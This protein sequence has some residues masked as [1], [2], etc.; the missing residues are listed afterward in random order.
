MAKKPIVTTINSVNEIVS[1][2]NTNFTNITNQFDNTLSRDGSTP[3]NMNADLDMNSNDVLNVN[4]IGTNDITVGGKSVVSLVQSTEDNALIASDA[5][6]SAAL[7]AAQA[8]LYDGIWLDETQSVVDDIALTYTA[9]QLGT[10]VAGDYISTKTGPSYIVAPS[11]AVDSD[12]TTAGLV[13]LYVVDVPN[14][15]AWVPSANGTI[16]E[17]PDSGAVF[18]TYTIGGTDDGTLLN[19]A[20]LKSLTEKNGYMHIPSGQYRVSTALVMDGGLGNAAR[21][22]S[23]RGDGQ[24][25]PAHIQYGFGRQGTS[26]LFDTGVSIGGVQQSTSFEDIAI[27]G[28]TTGTFINYATGF[29]SGGGLQNFTIVN[30]ATDAT[31]ANSVAIQVTALYTTQTL[32]GFIV[33]RR[34][35]R[36]AWDDDSIASSDLYFGTGFFCDT[37][38][39][40][41]IGALSNVTVSGFSVGFKVESDA[42]S[43]A[44]RIAPTRFE[45]FQFSYCQTGALFGQGSEQIELAAPFFEYNADN[46]LKWYDG[47]GYLSVKGGRSTG[48]TRLFDGGG[49][50]VAQFM[51]DAGF[52]FGDAVSLD[53]K[54]GGAVFKEHTF[55]AM[56][57]MNAGVMLYAGT[58]AGYVILEDCIYTGG[59]VVAMDMTNVADGVPDVWIKSSNQEVTQGTFPATSRWITA[60]TRGADYTQHTFTDAN[61]LGRIDGQAVTIN[62]G[63]SS[64]AVLDL[65]GRRF[66]PY[67]IEPSLG[68]DLTVTLGTKTWTGQHMTV[69]KRFASGKVDIVIPVGIAVYDRSNVRQTATTLAISPTGAVDRFRLE[70]INATEWIIT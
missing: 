46:H 8:A 34:D 3:N 65:T 16:A 69:N 63:G 6:S 41:G 4:N 27:Y 26:L 24:S 1:A 25:S 42:V 33:G 54:W 61:W 47:A 21:G 31:F 59:T 36:P 67:A 12:L 2:S 19:S 49:G 32:N 23:V 35:F 37:T 66:I 53:C 28:Q 29:V 57:N 10:V 11:D 5:A 38:G 17:N 60:F 64:K 40:G 55:S 45:N 51:R 15:A 58:D 43:S 18:T 9:E 13:K 48:V 20:I 14:F 50:P 44:K 56:A 68:I 70:K 22:F 52:V 30:N 7:S 39:Q 62:A